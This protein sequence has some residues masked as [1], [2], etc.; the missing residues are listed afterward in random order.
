MEISR[1][2]VLNLLV[3]LDRHFGGIDHTT[4][5]VDETSN[6]KLHRIPQCLAMGKILGIVGEAFVSRKSWHGFST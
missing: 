5:I 3:V 2:V 6:L 4:M 1:T